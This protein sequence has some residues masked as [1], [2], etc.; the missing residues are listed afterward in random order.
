M[1]DE[2]EVEE[3]AITVVLPMTEVPA[4]SVKKLSAKRYITAALSA[5]FEV[6]CAITQTVE[7]RKPFVSGE[8]A[9]K[10]RPDVETEHLWVLGNAPKAA[11]F[12]LHFKGGSFSEGWV[13][14]AAGWPTELWYDYAVGARERKQVKDEPAWAWK[15]RLE[16][17][18]ADIQRRGYEYNDRAFWTNLNPR[19]VTTA[20]AL[21]EW[22]ADL[23]PGFTVRKKAEKTV[24]APLTAVE[25]LQIGEWI[26]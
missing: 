12:K 1:T 15:D 23:V 11:R 26:G 10:P 4:E 20:A 9:G 8:N 16:R 17:L 5:G 13:W 6:R 25:E 18:D 19:L 7:A 22:M 24:A 3:P 14:D 2:A 21:D